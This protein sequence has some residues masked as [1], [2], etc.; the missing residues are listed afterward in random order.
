MASIRFQ[1]GFDPDRNQN[2]DHQLYRNKPPRRRCV[3][4]T[5]VPE[6]PSP[7][8]RLAKRADIGASSCAVAC[9]LATPLKSSAR[10]ASSPPSS[11]GRARGRAP[12]CAR[13]EVEDGRDGRRARAACERAD[14]DARACERM[15]RLLRTSGR[16]E[17]DET[18]STRAVV[19]TRARGMEIEMCRIHAHFDILQN[20]F[21]TSTCPNIQIT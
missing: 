4:A 16:R 3:S 10:G 9:S 20:T 11:L 14:V 8:S 2:F 18:T 13:N 7:N 12:V 6:S 17:R 19:S 15:R 21:N 5:S 1:A